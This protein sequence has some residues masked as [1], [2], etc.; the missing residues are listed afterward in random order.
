CHYNRDVFI[1]FEIE[2]FEQYQRGI[3]RRRAETTHTQ[4]FSLELLD[5]SDAG[6]PHD[7]IVVG[8]LGRCDEHDVMALQARLH[9]RS[10]VY[11]RRISTHQRLRRKL[12]AAKEDDLGV[13][14]MLLE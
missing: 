3:V 12:P 13:E 7:R 5:F 6:T 9:H 10:D 14:A 2:F 11:D 8:G 4:A 1:W